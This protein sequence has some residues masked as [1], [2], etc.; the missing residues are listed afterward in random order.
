MLYKK[1]DP[2]DPANYRPIGLALTIYKLW[3]ALITGVL[4][5]THQAL[6]SVL[7]ALEDAKLF[8]R[9]IYMLYIDFSAA[10]DTATAEACSAPAFADDLLIMTNSLL[11]L[12]HQA[13]KITSPTGTWESG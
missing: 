12:K 1:G 7:N 3:T 13:D 2:T 5:D 8:D 6:F 4:S 11:H 9:D 10:F